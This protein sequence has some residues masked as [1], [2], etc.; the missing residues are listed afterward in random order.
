MVFYSHTIKTELLTSMMRIVGFCLIFQR[1][2]EVKEKKQHI[3]DSI[4]YPS[5]SSVTPEAKFEGEKSVL[6][7]GN[8]FLLASKGEI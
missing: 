8:I 3:S 4:Y 7:C 2:F 5:T 1:S 6:Q